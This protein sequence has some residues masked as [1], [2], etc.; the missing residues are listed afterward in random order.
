MTS[1]PSF[2]TSTLG[3]SIIIAVVTFG[4]YASS[5]SGAFLWDDQVIIDNPLMKT[6]HGLNIIWTAPPRHTA[7]PHYWPLTYTLWWVMLKIFGPAPIA[8][9]LM[10]VALHIMN[11]LL[12]G[13][14]LR[15]LAVPGAMLAAAV[16]A[17]HPVH[18]ESVAWIVETK[19]LLS[20]AFYILSLGTL[21]KFFDAPHPLRYV[22]GL[23]LFVAGMLSKSVVVT[24]PAALL[25]IQWW[26]SGGQLTRR[27]WLAA[28]PLF[29]IAAVHTAYDQILSSL[30]IAT[31]QTAYPVLDRV[32]IAGRAFFSYFGKLV[33]PINLV[34]AYP[35]WPV[36][37]R[38]LLQWFWPVAAVS[39][40]A[41]LWGLRHRIGRTP[42]TVY[43]LYA[44]ILSPTL[45][46]IPHGFMSYAYYADRYQYLASAAPIA[47][48]AA[49]VARAQHKR[50]IPALAGGVLALYFVLTAIQGLYYHDTLTLFRRAAQASP[51]NASV[52]DVLARE[53]VR[54]NNLPMAEQNFRQALAANPDNP[55][56][57]YGLGGIL[58]RTGRP[59][60]A[61][62]FLDKARLARPGDERTHISLALALRDANRPG[63][64]AK[65]L[66]AAI[67]I[68]PFRQ[69]L[70]ALRDELLQK[71]AALDAGTT[72]GL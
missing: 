55:E 57:N 46:L 22:A 5:L 27:H 31:Q 40:A 8:F 44:V 32:L 7:E 26:R 10:N 59:A 68:A 33:L 61:V 35:Q 48:A 24:L 38:H 21:L 17:L 25:I 29:A 12:L 60:E 28:A 65:S 58:V 18:V 1:R 67:N 51:R 16:F 62:F 47:L 54:E 71:Q 4:A 42:F 36:D 43:A 14:L 69:D 3:L 50:L 30:V 20:G 66:G 49:L 19:D 45:G 56:C 6:A 34:A 52:L 11:S 53:Y 63:D 9:R 2:L 64:A 13:T 70:I 15:R 39:L 37:P 41:I 72:G 23:L